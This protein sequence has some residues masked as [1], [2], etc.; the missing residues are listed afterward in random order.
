MVKLIVYENPD[1]WVTTFIPKEKMDKVRDKLN[2]HGEW[3]V[4]VETHEQDS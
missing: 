1:T 2:E 3:F 4:F